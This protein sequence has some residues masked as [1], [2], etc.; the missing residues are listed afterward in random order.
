MKYILIV[1]T[2]NT[3]RSP[4]AAYLLRKMIKEHGATDTVE[5]DSAG[6]GAFGGDPI[7]ENALIA[8]Q[9]IG[10][11]ASEHRAKPLTHYAAAQADTIYVMT[12]AHRRTIESALP[13][14]SNQIKVIGVSDPYGLELSAYRNCLNE[15]KA[16]FQAELPYII[17]EKDENRIDESI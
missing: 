6:L 12:E 8:L 17:S 5:V 7:S 9:E 14:A 11:D 4:M 2:G 10:I 3:C 13:E 16:F 15:I 1:C